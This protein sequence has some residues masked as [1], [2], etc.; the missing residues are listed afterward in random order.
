MLC[1]RTIEAMIESKRIAIDS[2][3]KGYVNVE[4][5]FIDLEQ[6]DEEFEPMENG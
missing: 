4:E 3:V 5:L 6:E 2:S 1:E